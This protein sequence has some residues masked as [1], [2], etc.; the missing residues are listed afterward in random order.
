MEISIDFS[1]GR[2]AEYRAHSSHFTTWRDSNL[3]ITSLQKPNQPWIYSLPLLWIQSLSS[4]SL[5]RW[6]IVQ[7]D[8]AFRA[9]PLRWSEFSW[10]WRTKMGWVIP[11]TFVLLTCRVWC[12]FS[13]LELFGQF[14]RHVNHRNLQNC[15]FMPCTSLWTVDFEEWKKFSSL[16]GKQLSFPFAD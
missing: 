3:D 1:A 9:P 2:P 7:T 6:A 14:Q 10:V 5:R 13:Y 16:S 11:V 4:E 8:P 12:Q 15:C